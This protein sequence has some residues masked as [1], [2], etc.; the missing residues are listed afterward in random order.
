MKRNRDPKI[1]LNRRHSLLR[2]R[3][4][5]AFELG[6]YV[7]MSAK[8]NEYERVDFCEGFEQAGG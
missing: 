6:Q 1:V 7:H 8:T 4:T 5:C 3:V 2:R